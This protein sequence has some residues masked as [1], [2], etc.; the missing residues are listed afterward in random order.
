MRPLRLV[1]AASLT[2][3]ALV[4]ADSSSAHVDASSKKLPCTVLVA[5]DRIISAPKLPRSVR[6]DAAGMNGGG[7]DRLICRDVT[8]DKR[9]D[10]TVL[11]T[12]TANSGVTAW[13]VFRAKRKWVLSLARVHVHQCAVKT[14]HHDLLEKEPAKSGG[15]VHRRFHW[16]RAHKDFDVL[17]KWYTSS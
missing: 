11:I 14:K 16:D 7:V 12:S 1:L 4:A 13:V 10:M 5:R 17:R 8:F 2:A 6:D 15:Y 3:G 9:T